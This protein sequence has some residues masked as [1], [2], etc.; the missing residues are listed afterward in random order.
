M[1]AFPIFVL[2]QFS[3]LDLSTT[4]CAPLKGG[5]RGTRNGMKSPPRTL[6]VRG[7]GGGAGG[8]VCT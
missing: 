6:E 4:A 3:S 2:R 8:A 1:F 5:C 7:R